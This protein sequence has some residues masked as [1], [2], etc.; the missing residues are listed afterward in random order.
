MQ[1][2]QYKYLSLRTYFG[3]V[4]SLRS[5]QAYLSTVVAV[6]KAPCLTNNRRALNA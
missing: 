3:S 2:L 4:M 6:E 5:R 1:L